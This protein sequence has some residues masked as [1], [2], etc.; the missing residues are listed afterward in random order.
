MRFGNSAHLPKN[1]SPG[2]QPC[3]HVITAQAREVAK[4][5]KDKFE[6]AYILSRPVIPTMLRKYIE[7]ALVRM[8]KVRHSL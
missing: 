8:R 6:L 4:E 2:K 3:I 7:K 1:C 5:V